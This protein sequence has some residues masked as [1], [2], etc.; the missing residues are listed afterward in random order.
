[1]KRRTGRQYTLRLMLPVVGTI[2]VPSTGWAGGDPQP[3]KR[4]FLRCATCHAAEPAVH[5]NGP[6]LATVYGRAAASVEG[7][8][9]YSDALRRAD[10]VW[11]DETLDAWLRDPRAVAPGNTMVIP[12]IAAAR[13]RLDL[14]AYLKDLATRNRAA[15][16]TPEATRS[17]IQ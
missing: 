8:G 3:G 16:G 10:V 5:K 7:F 6:S 4:E 2:L 13:V 1:M 12:G 17:P 15:A 11:T 14:I 9:R